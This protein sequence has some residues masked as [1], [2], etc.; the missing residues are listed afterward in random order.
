MMACMDS[1]IK[2]SCQSI[3]DCLNELMQNLTKLITIGKMTWI[4]KEPEK[5]QP[6]QL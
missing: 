3:V 5:K 6:Q 4:E 1:D 2:N